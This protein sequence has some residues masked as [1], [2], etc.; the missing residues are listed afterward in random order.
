MSSISRR[1]FEPHNPG[2]ICSCVAPVGMSKVTCFV[3]HRYCPRRQV[4][5]GSRRLRRY[6]VQK[7]KCH[8]RAM[9]Y[10]RPF[11]VVGKFKPRR[12]DNSLPR[13]VQFHNLRRIA[14][15]RNCTQRFPPHWPACVGCGNI[16][17]QPAGLLAASAC[18]KSPCGKSTWPCASDLVAGH[19]KICRRHQHGIRRKSFGFMVMCE[20]PAAPFILLC[21][22]K[23]GREEA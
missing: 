23:R 6:C 7:T 4:W 1:P 17:C 8:A 16:S 15:S 19:R 10:F 5:A 21:N 12:Y 22:G 9:P 20:R 3:V 14:P 18:S 2:W 11:L 13:R